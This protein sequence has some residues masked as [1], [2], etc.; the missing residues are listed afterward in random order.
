MS[1]LIGP[2]GAGNRAWRAWAAGTGK[3]VVTVNTTDE[4]G[5]ASLVVRAVDQ[6]RN[7][8]ADVCEFVAAHSGR[9]FR[10]V[11][12]SFAT[13]THRDIDD[14]F[15]ANDGTLPTGP[16]TRLARELVPQPVWIDG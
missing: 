12:A 10:E 4:C 1:V 9:S 14:F 5:I 7:L 2:V 16:A 8:L 13:M 6:E 3:T 15:A 11:H